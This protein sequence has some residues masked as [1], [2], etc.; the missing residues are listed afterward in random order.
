MGSALGLGS[1]G[2]TNPIDS[3]VDAAMNGALGSSG[4]AS[5]AAAQVAPAPFGSLAAGL[6]QAMGGYGGAVP[7]GAFGGLAGGG[8][9]PVF[10]RRR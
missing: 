10:Y 2:A 9:R 6:P 3:I 8:M 1:G 5:N 4:S 7:L